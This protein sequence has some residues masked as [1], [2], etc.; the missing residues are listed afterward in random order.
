MST[1]VCHAMHNGVIENNSADVACGVTNSTHPYVTCCV[2]GDYCMSNSICLNPNTE[3][4]DY[5]YAA[6]CT[7]DTM[8]DAA[9]GTRCGGRNNA[10]IIYTSKGFWA[11]CEND[12]GTVN[13]SDPSKEE[14]PAPAPSKLATIQYLP[15]TASGTPTYAVATSTTSSTSTSTTTTTTTSATSTATSTASSS[16]SSSGIGAGTAAG[17]GVGSAAAVCLIAAAL[18]LWFFRKRNAAQDALVAGGP[19]YNSLGDGAWPQK[20]EV[21]AQP[22]YEL[23]RSE[24]HTELEGE[25]RS[26]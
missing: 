1:A 24:Q 8:E 14:W 26:M 23:D 12:A 16:S 17:I 18:A 20:S 19:P 7:D 15:P 4:G 22:V 9:C 21:L 13:C 10:E 5:Y 6:D 2:N 3:Q 11:C 25:P